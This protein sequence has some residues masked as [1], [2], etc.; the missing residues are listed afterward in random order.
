VKIKGADAIELN[1]LTGEVNGYPVLQDGDYVSF[2]YDLPPAGSLLLYLP[3]KKQGNFTLADKPKALE[4][5]GSDSGLQISRDRENVIT[6]EFCD[7]LIGDEQPDLKIFC[8]QGI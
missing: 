3:L 1:T 4:T 6:L 2:T 8:E 5:I 7:I